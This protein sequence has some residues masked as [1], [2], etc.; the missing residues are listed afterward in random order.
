[1]SSGIRIYSRRSSTRK[2]A[3][4]YSE[5]I[6]I[7]LR[8]SGR[9]RG[10]IWRKGP[11]WPRKHAAYI[12]GSLET[13]K[14][15]TLLGPELLSMLKRQRTVVPS[16]QKTQRIAAP[17]GVK[18]RHTAVRFGLTT[19]RIAALFGQKTQ[20]IAALFGQ[21]TQRIAV[22]SLRFLFPALGWK[23]L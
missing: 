7:M 9:S 4:R 16:E 8:T 10:P 1:M 12:N 20:R 11:P 18:T 19:R 6:C 13:P 21:K 2:T 17:S 3:R 14:I 22:L 15:T 23:I 5:S